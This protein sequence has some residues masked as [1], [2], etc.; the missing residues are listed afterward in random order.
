MANYSIRGAVFEGRDPAMQA[1][2]ADLH[3]LKER[4][5]CQCRS[6]G[7]PMYVA[8]LGDSWLIKRMPDTGVAH[9][10]NCESYEPPPELSGLGQ[11]LGRAITEDIEQGTTALKLAF[12]LSKAVGRLAPSASD[13]ESDTVRTDGTK[14]SLRSVLHYLWEDAGLNSWSP[15]MAGKRNWLVVQKY[16]TQA[17]LGKVAKGAP[18]ADSLF[19]PEAHFSH[20]RDEIARRRE[21]KLAFLQKGVKGAT[22]LMILIGEVREIG[23]SRYGYKML[24]KQLPDFPF[25]LAEDVHRRLVKRFDGELALWDTI[26]DCHLMVIGT[27]GIGSSGVATIEELALMVTSENWIPF[28][29]LHQKTLIDMLTHQHRRFRKCLRYNMASGRPLATVV[30]TDTQPKPVAMYLIEAGASPDCKAAIEDLAAN[31]AIPH[32][33]WR[34]GDEPMPPLPATRDLNEISN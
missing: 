3:R 11:V 26:E 25:M 23:A 31:S 18:L 14:L 5:L 22:R 21:A 24:I 16:L 7:V 1:A 2:L 8:R 12:A 28:D 10:P 13:G 4:P 30:L 17:S 33:L 6:P 34:V 29:D 32:W 9:V 15:R 19:L 27:F 20:Q